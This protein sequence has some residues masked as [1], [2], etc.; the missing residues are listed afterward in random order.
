M[1][2]S[3]LALVEGERAKARKSNSGTAGVLTVVIIT[4]SRDMM[5]CAE[6]VVVLQAGRVVEEGSFEGLIRRRGELY[7]MLRVG[8]ALAAEG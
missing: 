4:H 3:V 2:N 6:N 5:A 1:R 7:E 8:G